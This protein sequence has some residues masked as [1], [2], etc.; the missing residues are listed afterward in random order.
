MASWVKDLAVLLLL[1][2]GFDPWLQNF[3]M[4]QAQLKN[5][6]RFDLEASPGCTLRWIIIAHHSGP[7]LL[8]QGFFPKKIFFSVNSL[9]VF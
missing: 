3:C 5:N 9:N 7:A 1:W 4:P 8:G 2:Y 6:K